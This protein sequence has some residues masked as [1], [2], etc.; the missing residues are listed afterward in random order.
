MAPTF[1]SSCEE[2]RRHS[3]EI[4]CDADSGNFSRVQCRGPMCF[5]VSPDTGERVNSETFSRRML[6]DMPCTDTGGLTSAGWLLMMSVECCRCAI[7]I[8][9]KVFD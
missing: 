2:Q 8:K 9:K 6:S 4:M 3:R 7:I 1:R 5:C